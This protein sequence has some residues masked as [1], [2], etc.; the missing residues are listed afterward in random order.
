MCSCTLFPVLPEFTRV[1]YVRP[2]PPGEKL[3]FSAGHH[4]QLA[5]VALRADTGRRLAGLDLLLTGSWVPHVRSPAGNQPRLHGS[6][7][8]V[9]A[10][11]FQLSACPCR[12]LIPLC[13]P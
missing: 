8:Q 4:G 11:G 12:D 5:P 7:C 6:F 9:G 2:L 10:S 1:L 13:P 3:L